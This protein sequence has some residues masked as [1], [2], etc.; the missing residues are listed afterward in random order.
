MA[1][2]TQDIPR[3]PSS[4]TM[5][6]PFTILT[7]AQRRPSPASLAAGAELSLLTDSPSGESTRRCKERGCVFPAT[8]PG[9]GRCRQHDRQHREP[10]LFGSQQPSL[11]LLDRA[12][13]GWL[14]SDPARS[15][16]RAEDRRHMARLWQA[17]QEGAS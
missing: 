11:L 10:D 6:Q 3:H 7:A 2:I 12:K 17:F 8:Q 16:S 4:S 13:F 14:D 5:I 15:E 9:G 1:G